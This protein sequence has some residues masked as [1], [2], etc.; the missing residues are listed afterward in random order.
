MS[1]EQAV[2]ELK[3]N[4][5]NAIIENGVVMVIVPDSTPRSFEKAFCKSKRVAKQIGYA[6]SIGVR[7]AKEGE[8]NG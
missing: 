4:G 3:K 2:E 6:N 5:L 1:K 8:C 7:S